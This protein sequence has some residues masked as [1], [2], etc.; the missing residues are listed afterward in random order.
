MERGLDPEREGKKQEEEED[1]GEIRAGFTR[2]GDRI[3][4]QI[5]GT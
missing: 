1:G 3:E 5:G 4:S 2:G